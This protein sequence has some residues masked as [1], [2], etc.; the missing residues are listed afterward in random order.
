MKTLKTLILLLPLFILLYACN[1]N[2]SNSENNQLSNGPKQSE[3]QIAWKASS[4]LVRKI[5]LS[6]SIV[7]RNKN[8][9]TDINLINDQLELAET[10]PDTGKSYSLYFDD[11]DLNFVD[12]TYRPNNKGQLSEIE[13]NVFFDD[14]QKVTELMQN[15]KSYF[16]VKFGA[17][18]EKGKKLIWLKDKKTHVELEDASRSK[19]A[20]FIILL[21]AKP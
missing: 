16:D 9:G 8:W 19:D 18:V 11:T 13:M 1:Q 7:I 15:F 21:K 10:Q 4:D 6:D 14:S 5:T 3:S 20:G 2:T 17:S 12:I